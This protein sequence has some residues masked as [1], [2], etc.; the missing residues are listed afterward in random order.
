MGI[1]ND[2]FN[3]SVKESALSSDVNVNAVMKL[4]TARKTEWEVGR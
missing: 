1:G 2:F 4:F 3:V